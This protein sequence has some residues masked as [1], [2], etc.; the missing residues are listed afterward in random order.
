[1]HCVVLGAGIAGVTTAWYLAR[2]A[3][4]VTVLERRP[5]P[6]LDASY[7]NGGLLTPSLSDP[8]AAPGVPRKML[9][10]LGREDAPLLLR[11]RA[12]PGM[13][14][15]GLRFLANCRSGPWR[16][17]TEAILRLARFSHDAFAELTA[18]C[19]IEFDRGDRGTLR[20]YRDGTS[21]ETG[22]RIAAMYGELDLPHRLLTAEN[23]AALEPSLRTVARDIAGGVH[24]TGDRSGDAFLFTKALASEAMTLGVDFATKCRN[25]QWATP[26]RRHAIQFGTV[27]IEWRSAL[28]V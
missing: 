17:N 20:I 21:W 10:W 5:G 15:W 24:Y 8:W 1:M 6:G 23:R 18:E 26:A 28:A 2:A 13:A 22:R 27:G 4:A 9:H 19:G 25:A 3:H 11:V 7:A 12:I 14:G 16:R